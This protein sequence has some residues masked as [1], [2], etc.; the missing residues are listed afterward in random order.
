MTAG[1][2][3][4]LMKL[5]T[6]L[7]QISE[8]G[9][10]SNELF[11]KSIGDLYE[12]V[13]ASSLRDSEF[14]SHL[15]VD[16]LDRNLYERSDD[17]RWWA[18]TPELRAALAAPTLGDAARQQISDILAYINSL[19]TV[20]TRLFVYDQQGCIVASTQPGQGRD[21]VIGTHIDA[22][23][24]ARVRALGSEQDYHVTPFE[25]SPLYGDRPTYVYHAAIRD[26]D[27]E[28]R[29][30]GGIGIVFDA[31]P[32]FA[33]MLRGGL[34]EQAGMQAL[35]VDR[36][37]RVI[38][39]LDPAR[40]VGSVLELDDTLRQLP[41]GQS[42]SRIVVHDGQYAIMGCTMSSG[43]REFKVTD[44]YREDVLAIVFKFLGEVR[45]A[46][47]DS[48]AARVQLQT[49]LRGQAGCEYATFV[50]GGALYALPAQ[51]ALEALPASKITTVSTGE[52]RAC[53]G[54]LGLQREGRDGAPVWVF[55]LGYLIRGTPSPTDN[56]SQVI[57]VRHGEQ[58]LGLLVDELHAVPEFSEQ[59]IMATPFGSAGLVR[60]FIKAN[61]G[62]VLIQVI[63]PASLFATLMQR[64]ASAR[65]EAL[66]A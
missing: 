14:V 47:G 48:G 52:R 51:H 44:G 56:R 15:L 43:Y 4:E 42:A 29:V 31:E 1:Q 21:S 20:Y 10:R 13:L 63:D 54:L 53:V 59:Q 3:G 30:V 41:N 18:L 33:A 9:A 46:S 2:R 38:S 39:S 34:G 7:D 17:C 65:P 6:I 26:P 37:G 25:T 36:Q 55:D 49:D 57:I 23:T 50:I 24:L 12:T 62:E 27:D 58:T 40:P 11:S 19:Y 8:T 64:E 28:A 66:A 61:G 45:E 16:L 35:F 32:E 5:K 22:A 60:H